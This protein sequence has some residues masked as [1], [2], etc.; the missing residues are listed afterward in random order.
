MT[1]LTNSGLRCCLMCE[2]A[3]ASTGGGRHVGNQC[4]AELDRGASRH[5]QV[6]TAVKRAAAGL[7][8]MALHSGRNK[9]PRTNNHVI[10]DESCTASAGFPR[11]VATKRVYKPKVLIVTFLTDTTGREIPCRLWA[12]VTEKAPSS[13]PKGAVTHPRR[14]SANFLTVDLKNHATKQTVLAISTRAQKNEPEGQKSTQVFPARPEKEKR[15]THG[16]HT[17][18]DTAC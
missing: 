7:I 10:R 14:R 4:A 17:K 15:S 12:L 2:R 11:P 5:F 13:H 9:S 18:G 1:K 16:P 8:S 3:P 6:A